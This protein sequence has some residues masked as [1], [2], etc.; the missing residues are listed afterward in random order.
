MAGPSF[1]VNINIDEFSN[2]IDFDALI[3]QEIRKLNLE[4][5]EGIS[6]EENLDARKYQAPLIRKNKPD[7]TATPSSASLAGAAGAVAAGSGAPP[8][9]VYGAASD[10]LIR[11]DWSTGRD[12][13]L[14][15]EMIGPVNDGPVGWTYGA[16]IN[17]WV[18]LVWYGDNVEQVGYETVTTDLLKFKEDN[19]SAS[20][21]IY[22][23]RGY[24]YAEAGNDVLITVTLNRTNGDSVQ[25]SEVVQCTLFT[26]RQP[27]DG[28]DLATLVVDLNTATMTVT[29]TQ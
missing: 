24:W 28:Q 29:K 2:L 21:I 3:R 14:V 17:Q 22:S 6:I 16:N 26:N 4:N 13:D 8:R 19:P 12:F 18:W 27:N 15:V 23:L 11:F 25:I 10:I 9:P 1:N 5:I 7:R 20:E